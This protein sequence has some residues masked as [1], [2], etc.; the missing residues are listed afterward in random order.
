MSGWRGEFGEMIGR[1]RVGVETLSGGTIS[2]LFV[3]PQGNFS[4]T[5]AR[6]H[7]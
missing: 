3:S 2:N 4:G 7:F 5:G 6:E 1:N